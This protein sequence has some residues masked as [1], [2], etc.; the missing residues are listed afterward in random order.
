[1]QVM[2]KILD[3]CHYELTVK[4]HKILKTII[5]PCF[6][7]ADGIKVES[8]VAIGLHKEIIGLFPLVYGKN[9]NK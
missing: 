8:T 6:P 2:I 4:T 3:E 9:I 1:M 7:L 5:L